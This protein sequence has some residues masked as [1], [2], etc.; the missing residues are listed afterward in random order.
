MIFCTFPDVCRPSNLITSS[1]LMPQ[2]VA[3]RNTSSTARLVRN[4]VHFD[5]GVDH[6]SCLDR[7]ACQ[8]GILELFSEH[9]IV[10][11]EVAGILEIGRDPHDIGQCR[12]LFRENS[13]NSLNRAPRFFLY[14]SR[15]HVAV[16]ILRNL[17][18][19]EDKVAR[20][21]RRMKWQVRIFL[22]DRIDI[23]A[24][25]ACILWHPHCAPVASIMSTPRTRSTR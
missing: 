16:S 11:A 2:C 7:G 13:T 22:S 18:R 20:A 17:A 5:L 3:S 25:S 8:H 14:R 15:D 1:S 4:G 24:G 6:R 23:L 9:S 21:H 19:N 10:A 12:S